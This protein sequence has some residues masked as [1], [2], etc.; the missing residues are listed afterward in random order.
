MGNQIHPRVTP[1]RRAWLEKLD[2]DGTAHRPRGNVGC[3]CMSLGWTEWAYRLLSGDVLGTAAM[4]AQYGPMSDWPY[5][6]DA[7]EQ[8]TDKGRRVL[9]EA[10]KS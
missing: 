4:H 3:Q 1:G 10:R 6:K 7:G 2:N 9:E 8:L 5:V